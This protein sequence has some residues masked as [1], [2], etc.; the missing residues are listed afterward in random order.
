MLFFSTRLCFCQEHLIIFSGGNLY[1]QPK[2]VSWK[3]SNL[4]AEAGQI[5]WPKWCLLTLRPMFN[6]PMVLLLDALKDWAYDLEH[7]TLEY[8]N[9]K[10]NQTT[11]VIWNGLPHTESFRGG[12][13]YSAL[14]YFVFCHQCCCYS[15]TVRY[16]KSTFTMLQ[17]ATLFRLTWDYSQIM[18]SLAQGLKIH[19]IARIFT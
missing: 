4:T 12:Q 6:N 11:K 16:V 13:R 3:S 1:L 2:K 5:K 15:F 9:S 17:N 14:S 19:L 18:H 8:H 7:C 10:K